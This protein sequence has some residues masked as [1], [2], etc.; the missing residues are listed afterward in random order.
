MCTLA[1]L[2]NSMCTFNSRSY[3]GI[4]L[5]YLSLTR[6]QYEA[7]VWCE[8]PGCV[9]PPAGQLCRVFP[10]SV[11]GHL[12]LPGHLQCPPTAGMFR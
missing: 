9:R 5:I 12:R 6:V 2:K 11:H 7:S 3:V 1:E 10:G 8:H 4:M